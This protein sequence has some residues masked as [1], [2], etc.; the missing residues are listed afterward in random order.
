[1]HVHLKLPL[2][3]MRNLLKEN[4][5]YMDKTMQSIKMFKT[6][7]NKS[8]WFWFGFAKRHFQQCFIGTF[9]FI[10]PEKTWCTRT[11]PKSYVNRTKWLAWSKLHGLMADSI[12]NWFTHK[13]IQLISRQYLLLS[14]TL[15]FKGVRRKLELCVWF[16]WHVY[17][18]TVDL[19]R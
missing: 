3:I 12:L 9:S 4:G 15:G 10:R 11:N 17:L 14:E 18:R 2:K 5:G 6:N 1:M 13:T 7:N 16:K 8:F 19:V